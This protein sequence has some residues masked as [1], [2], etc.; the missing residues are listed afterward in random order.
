MS[1]V[2]EPSIHTTINDN[3]LG[4][5]L[6]I[7]SVLLIAGLVASLFLADLQFTSGLAIGGALGYLNYFWLRSSLGRMLDRAA[8]GTVDP[9]AVW[10]I[11]H[12]LRFFSIILIVIG[13][14]VTGLVPLIAVVS[15]LLFLALAIVVEGFIQIFFTVFRREEI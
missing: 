3:V 1:E 13:I 5:I 6:I 2:S 11:K 4:R 7:K 14:H 10:V 9:T 8:A 15:G 12:N